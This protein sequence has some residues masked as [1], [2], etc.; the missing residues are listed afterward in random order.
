MDDARALATA[1]AAPDA[2]LSPLSSTP[3]KR[4]YRINRPGRTPWLLLVAPPGSVADPRAD[5]RMLDFLARHGYPA[6]RVVRT[7]AGDTVCAGEQGQV[8]VTTFVE[9][10]ALPAD[11]EAYTRLGQAVGR[12]H[13]LPAS[14]AQ[15]PLRP[16]G[17]LPR[18]EL[19]FARR[20]LATVRDRVPAA[21][22]A[23]FEAL[24]AACRADAWADGLPAV[25][26]H[27]DCHPANA[28]QTP[29]GQVVLIDWEGAGLG[30]AIIDLGFLLVSCAV[31]LPAGWADA[32]RP[33]SWAAAP[34]QAAWQ[35][36]APDR[37][38]L[39]AVI[40]G[41]RRERVPS[42]AELALLPEALRFRS[43]VA[44]ACALARQIDRGLAVDPEPW[45]SARLAAV[46]A[47]AAE[48][49]QRLGAV[50]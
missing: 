11:R 37:A 19:A 1:Y 32:L 39:A 5:A 9:G 31:P 34:Q 13:V 26:L 4:L 20:Q 38:L 18:N 49:R 35:T 43:L 17:M 40:D 22:A 44:A 12:L 30:P 27:N 36:P 33:D 29:D 45:W 7:T 3:S 23:R 16:A 8:L 6:P 15:P 46:D 28:I 41:Y 47:L 10:A 50:L 14:A 24:A 2:V 21:L 25:L 48:A 42:A